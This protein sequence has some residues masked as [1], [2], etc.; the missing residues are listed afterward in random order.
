MDEYG[1]R[2]PGESYLQ[3]SRETSV[4]NPRSLKSDRLY[5]PDGF[6]IFFK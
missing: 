5:V 6:T 3:Y 1:T 2:F 4:V